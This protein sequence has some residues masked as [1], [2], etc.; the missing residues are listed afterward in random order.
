M[1][2]SEVEF[3]TLQSYHYNSIIQYKYDIKHATLAL[4]QMINDMWW[5]EKAHNLFLVKLHEGST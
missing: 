4:G 1:R 2:R 5:K 3:Y